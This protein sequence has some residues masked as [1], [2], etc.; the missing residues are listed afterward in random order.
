MLVYY[1]QGQLGEEIG[2]EIRSQ[3]VYKEA[4][5][6][7]LT[8]V[9]WSQ[10]PSN[11]STCWAVCATRRSDLRRL[12]VWCQSFEDLH[13]TSC[14]ELGRLTV[15][16]KFPEPPHHLRAPLNA[17]PHSFRHQRSCS[18]GPSRCSKLP[19]ALE[20]L[21]IPSTMLFNP[22]SLAQCARKSHPYVCSSP[23]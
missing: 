14:S 15:F 9:M 8:C 23:A 10:S 20:D 4:T 1:T 13:R 5:I 21:A 7:L 22:K 3:S 11:R 19:P 2:R 6:M 18:R 17:P 12:R 16:C